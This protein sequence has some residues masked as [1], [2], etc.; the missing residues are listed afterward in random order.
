[1]DISVNGK[2]STVKGKIGDRSRSCFCLSSWAQR[3]KD[4]GLPLPSHKSQKTRFPPVGI[5]CGTSAC[6]RIPLRSVGSQN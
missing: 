5:W 6:W 3:T 1:M 2:R 4:L